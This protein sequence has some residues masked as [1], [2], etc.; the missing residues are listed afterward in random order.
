MTELDLTDT[1]TLGIVAVVAVLAGFVRGFTGFGGPAVMILILA[2]FYAPLSLI[3]KVLVIDFFANIKLVP[4]T[5]REVEL[6]TVVPVILGTLIG[7]PFGFY[8]LNNVNPEVMSRLI[9]VVAGCLT[10]VMM[11]GVRFARIPPAWMHLSLGV[12]AGVV[13]GATNIAFAAAIYF[14][15]MP[16]LA[17][18][19]RANI[20][21][22]GFVTSIVLITAHIALDNLNWD[23]M[24]RSAMLGIGY[25]GGAH[26][27][28]AV[29]RRT[30]E[31]DFRR[32]VLWLLLGLALAGL[33]V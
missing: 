27:G 15:A 16:G 17:A 13:L 21:L 18:S 33:V 7:G 28:D 5:A 26:V 4:A 25:L 8:A 11:G 32:F 12:V 9:A 22:W 30:K 24:W 10:V 20:V 1:T 31:Q 23:G 14:L 19:G 2:P 29:F 6:R 3:S